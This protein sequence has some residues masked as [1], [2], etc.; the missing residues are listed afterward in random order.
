MGFLTSYKQLE[1]L[2]G[3]RLK[4]NRCISAY[5]D[6]MQKT[7]RGASLVPGWDADLKKLKHYRWIRNQLAH[8]PGCTEKNMCRPEDTRWLNTFRNRVLNY[9]DPLS[10]YRKKSLE[11]KRSRSIVPLLILCILLAAILTVLVW[12]AWIA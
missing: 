3:E 1:K 9:R 6:Q 11:K 4:D 2:C 7:T 8:E 12:D 5:I 10:L